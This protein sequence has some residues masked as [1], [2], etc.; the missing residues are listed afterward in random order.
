MPDGSPLTPTV[1]C[2]AGSPPGT[3]RTDLADCVAGDTYEVEVI[4][5]F[6]LI[7]PIIGTMFGGQLQLGAS[8]RAIVLN[9]AFDPS[10]GATA[11]KLVEAAGALNG[12]D[13]VANCLEPEDFDA[14][15]FYRSPCLDSSTPDPI[16]K[17]HLLFETGDQIRYKITVGNNGG[18]TLTGLTVVDSL[19]W[20]GSCA[21]PPSSLAAGA[22]DYACVYQRTA[23]V[24]T[25][26]GP[27]M[28]LVNQLTVDANQIDPVVDDV[29][30]LIER[31]AD[32]EVFK[33]VSP[34]FEGNDGDGVP[35]FGNT[36]AITVHTRAAATGQ[37]LQ[38]SVWY[39]VFIE[40]IGSKTA[41]GVQI[42]DTRNGVPVALPYGQQNATADCDAQPTTM[43]PGQAFE[44]RY[45]ATYTGTIDQTNVLLITSPD[46]NTDGNDQDQ[47]VVTV[48]DCGQNN[49]RVVPNVVGLTRMQAQAAW[50]AAAFTGNL[51]WPG[52]FS[53]PNGIVMTQ[54]RQAYGCVG[55]NSN[56]TITNAVTP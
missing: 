52:S 24:V 13:I 38:V 43:N 12:S 4:Y 53:D 40:N 16:D 28:D 34:Y 32:F 47:V 39:R 26:G 44:C 37:T 45:R 46:V 31:P 6:R 17:L 20:P 22:P 8:S 36:S 3:A 14:A 25:G 55:R 18:Q 33:Q 1:V 54:S 15:G 19:G 27:S 7:T 21:T 2:Y 42:V 51:T 10:P 23:P 11:Q 50:T 48:N 56:M 35:T 49:D 30:V 29:T 5:P 41:T 9:R